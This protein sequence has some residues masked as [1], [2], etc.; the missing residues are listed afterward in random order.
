MNREE[1]IKKIN[2]DVDL[3]MCL[4]DRVHD[5]FSRLASEVNNSGVEGQ[6]EWLK[7]TVGEDYEVALKELEFAKKN[8]EVA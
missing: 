1:V 8:G 3:Q 5:H 7:E 4:D 6:L 2:G